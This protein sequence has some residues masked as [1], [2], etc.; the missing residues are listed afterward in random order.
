MDRED[1]LRKSRDEHQNKDVFEKEV[2]KEGGNAG[3][4][5]A[6]LLATLFFILQIAA[7]AGMDYGLYAVVFSIPAAAFLVK[8]VRL[9]RRH[10]IALAVVYSVFV[11][12]LSGAHIFTLFQAAAGR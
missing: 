4:C 7:G 5:A 12:S 1:I 11:L 2:V 3:A 10:E 9:K 6:G 8:A